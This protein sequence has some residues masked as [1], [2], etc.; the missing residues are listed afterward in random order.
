MRLPDGKAFEVEFLDFSGS[1]QPHTASLIK[2]M[3]LVGIEARYRIVDAA[4]YQRRVESFDFDIVT[5][6]S[7][8]GVTPGEGLPLMFGSRAAGIPGSSNIVGIADPAVDAMVAA[9]L[10]ADT[11]AELTTACRALDR[12]LRAGRYWIPMW[13]KAAHWLAYWDMYGRPATK[14]KY[15]RGVPATWWYEEEKAKQIGK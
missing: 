12:V 7:S 1:L 2:N 6:R 5:R 4:Q 8:M 10:A 15:D 14:P 9:A 11:R 13:S 3:K